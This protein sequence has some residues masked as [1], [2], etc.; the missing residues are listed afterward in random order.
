MI[1]ETYENGARHK[2]RWPADQG[3]SA[4]D[5]SIR[6]AEYLASHRVSLAPRTLLFGCQGVTPEQYIQCAKGI[7]NVAQPTDWFG[8]GARCILGRQPSL[9]PEHYLTALEIVPLLAAKRLQHVHIFGVLYDRAIAPF[10]WLCHQ[11]NIELSTDSAAPA[12]AVTRPD[13]KRAGVRAPGL[14]SLPSRP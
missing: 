6:A 11:F 3:F 4:V 10:A 12:L 2:K 14:L 9:L 7:L 8:F 1:D 13:P 5:A